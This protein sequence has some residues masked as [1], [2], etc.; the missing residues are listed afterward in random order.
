[1]TLRDVYDNQG[2]L[3]ETWC[4]LHLL[5]KGGNGHNS[6]AWTK[7]QTQRELGHSWDSTSSGKDVAN[8]KGGKF[9]FE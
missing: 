3:E 9:E 5:E 6:S 8:H 7:C 1:M 4:A 2:M